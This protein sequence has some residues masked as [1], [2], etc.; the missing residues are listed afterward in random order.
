MIQLTSITP[1]STACLV[2]LGGSGGFRRRLLE[3]GLLPGTQVRLVRQARL[4]NLV[5]LEVRGC[6]LS[7]RRSEAREVLVEPG[8]PT[9]D[10]APCAP[11]SAAVR[12]SVGKVDCPPT[13]SADH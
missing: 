9:A 3:M 12:N 13:P 7:L 4:G 2:A 6:H 10:R 1:G 8:R 11:T 5:E